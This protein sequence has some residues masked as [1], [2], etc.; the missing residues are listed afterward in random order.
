[1]R[2]GS[3]IA[4]ATSSLV[5]LTMGGYGAISLHQRRIE[6][7]DDLARRTVGLAQFIA[8]ALEEEANLRIKGDTLQLAGR[9]IK[10]QSGAQLRIL[11]LETFR[12]PDAPADSKRRASDV[13]AR[14][15]AV[16]E[17]IPGGGDKPPYLA[18]AFPIRLDGQI[19]G[20]LELQH[21]AT[22]IEQ[23]LREAA[24]RM[25]GT[26]VGLLIGLAGAVFLIARTTISRPLGRMLQEI[27]EVA[28][29][30]LTRTVFA[31]RNDEA[32][33][34]AARFNAMTS[35]LREAREEA[36]R[37]VETR[38]ELEQRLR[39]S[40][41]LATVGQLSAEIAHEVGTP[42]AVIGGRARSMERKAAAPEEVA[43]NAGIIAAQA[44]RITKIIERLLRFA[45]RRGGPEPGTVDLN[46]VAHEAI[47]FLEHQIERGG[48]SLEFVRGT[49]I[50]EI[51]G[52]PDAIQ[53]VCLNLIVNAIQAM[54]GGGRLL[55]ATS[56]VTRR[57]EGLEAAAAG[58]YACIEV[59]DNGVGIPEEERAKIFEP[60]YSTKEDGSGL[61]LAVS[62]GIVKDHD[63]WVE[64]EPGPTG[65]T[66][67]RV[68]LPASHDMVAR[69]EESA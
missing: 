52:D 28:K 59:T 4:L 30:D 39:H 57:R 58:A 40:E 49:G 1:V 15:Q 54:P 29:G 24:L 20:V 16:Q 8:A 27:G 31:E 26:L 25:L 55:V 21:D 41:K 17:F 60:F 22:F 35:S 14:D 6:L 38:L 64:V 46:R 32:G 67:F 48:V 62:H 13:R 23:T 47:E 10:R 65:G 19:I 5:A 68:F 36:R 18:L 11:N 42:L 7:E 2:I 12:D 61:G 63:G 66:T 3:R 45:R 34:L 53:Q 50:G 9:L 44:T 37:G 51:P 69:L 43:R 56:R 33:E